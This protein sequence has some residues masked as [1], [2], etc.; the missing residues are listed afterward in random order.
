MNRTT[1]QFPGSGN[2]EREEATRMKLQRRRRGKNVVALV[3][4]LAAMGFGL[5]WLVWILFTTVKLGIGGLSIEL[6]TQ[7]TPP[8]NTDGGGLLNANVGSLMLVI[9]ATIVGTPL[10]ILAGV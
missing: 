8:P 1:T 5:L 7:N 6:F 4:S 9:L 2:P 3:L 10:G